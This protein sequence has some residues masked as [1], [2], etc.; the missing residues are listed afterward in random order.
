LS[1]LPTVEINELNRPFHDGLRK[2][3]L[4]LQCCPN[5]A[6]K[7]LPA[8]Q[9]CPRCLHAD[10]EWTASAGLGSVRSWVVFHRAYH[11]YFRDRVPYN[12]ALVRL[13]EGPQ[14]LTNV[15]TSSQGPEIGIGARVGLR[16]VEQE[17]VHLAK[18]EILP[19]RTG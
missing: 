3:R 9:A 11:P 19:G 10:P 4:M 8:R 6:T 14:L 5:C 7:W 12:V 16:V 2:G 1:A 15:L 18:F 17:G 13:D